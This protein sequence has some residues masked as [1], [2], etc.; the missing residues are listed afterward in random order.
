MDGVPFQAARS[1]N[2]I[3]LSSCT[4]SPISSIASKP[5]PQDSRPMRGSSGGEGPERKRPTSATKKCAPGLSRRKT[6][7]FQL[8]AGCVMQGKGVF[9]P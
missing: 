9:T 8:R 1:P 2:L 5:E 4:G 7:S 6:K 3:M